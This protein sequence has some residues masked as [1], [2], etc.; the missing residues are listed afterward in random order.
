MH[1]HTQ[2]IKKIQILNNSKF[3]LNKEKKEKKKKRKKE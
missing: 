2:K 1:T 3:K